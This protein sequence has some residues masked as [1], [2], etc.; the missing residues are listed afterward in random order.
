MSKYIRTPKGK[1]KYAWVSKADTKFNPD[2]E[3]KINLIAD[4]EDPEV[5]ELCARL[6]AL[7]EEAKAK[8]IEENPKRS[9]L[10]A[11]AYESVTDDKGNE[12]GEVTFKF[13]LKAK[14]K[15][16]DGKSYQQRPTVFDAKGKPITDLDDFGIGDGSI[17]KV[18]FDPVTY[19]MASTKTAGVSLRLKAVQVIKLESWNGGGSFGFEEE[20]GYE[21]SAQKDK[22]GD[23]E[24]VFT[25]EESGDEDGDY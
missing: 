2:G 1:S 3:Y 12:T 19:F 7:V 6:D 17:V 18:A 4:A 10:T 8:A 24:T 11:P 9:P 23:N 16:K 20:E 21:Y 15:T 14:V 13:K 5:Q 25:E 22:N